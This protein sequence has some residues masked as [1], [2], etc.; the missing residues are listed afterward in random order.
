MK[1]VSPLVFASAAMGHNWLKS[2]MPFGGAK[3]RTVVP[4]ENKGADYTP[5]LAG[6]GTSLPL[7][8]ST[9]HGG[10]HHVKM[11]PLTHGNDANATDYRAIEA[12]QPIV[13]MPKSSG[14][15]FNLQLPDTEG[16]VLV[17]YS[18]ANY[19]NCFQVNVVSGGQGTPTVTEAPVDPNVKA[20]QGAN[21]AQYCQDFVA[22]CTAQT[23]P[24]SAFADENECMRTCATYP[25]IESETLLAANN[26]I[27]TGNSLQCRFFHLHVEGI[28]GSGAQVVS[29]CAHASKTGG[30]EVNEPK[31]T[32]RHEPNL[33]MTILLTF[34][35][36]QRPLFSE[37]DSQMSDIMA[38]VLDEGNLVVQGAVG[39]GEHDAVVVV[40]LR[41]AAG[42]PAESALAFLQ[43]SLEA[44]VNTAFPNQVQAVRALAPD[45][46][47]LGG[48]SGATVSSSIGLVA[49]LPL[50]AALQ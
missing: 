12:L 48:T 8:W 33:G 38:R 18:W 22:K 47:T 46:R 30:T 36:G 37:I 21:C 42:V 24:L 39:V 15:T 25:D 10:D 35:E 16:K 7:T 4:C 44:D 5:T 43:E 23:A 17:Q 32:G 3:A 28:E 31:C 34:K 2:P 9:N 40:A 26:T 13:S 20:I 41:D 49:L 27:V 45:G 14:D 19:R 29:H 11:Y 50:L 6:A 1:F